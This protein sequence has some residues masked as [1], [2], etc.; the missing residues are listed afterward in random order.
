LGNLNGNP[1]SG[2]ELCLIPSLGGSISFGGSHNYDG[3]FAIGLA[4]GGYPVV[5]PPTFSANPV[6]AGSSVTVSAAVTGTGPFTYQWQTDGGNGGALTDIP[7]ATNPT[8]TVNTTGLDNLTVA[9]RLV[10]SNGAGSTTGEASLLTVNPGSGPFVRPGFDTTPS[11]ADRFVGGAVTFTAR[12]DGTLPISYQ[13][14][15]NK[16]S[17]PE[18]LAGQ[19][20]DTLVLSNL[21]LADAGQYSLHAI[22]SV[23]AADSTPSTLTVLPQPA[24]PMTVNLQWRSFQ[25]GNDVGVYS[26]TGVLGSGTYWN[27]IIGPTAGSTPGTFTSDAPGYAD[28]GVTVAGLSMTI[29]SSES[30]CW[31]S[32]PTIPLLDSAATAFGTQNFSFIL[33]NGLYNIVLFSCDGTEAGTDTQ[34]GTIFDIKGVTH[35]AAPTQ[36]TSFVAGDNYVVFS[37]VVVTTGALTGT[38]SQNTA[39]GARVG[40]LN[41][42]Q[43]EYLGAVNTTQPD[44]IA[45]AA[46]GQ[47]SLSWPGHGGWTLQV[48]TNS[49][50][51][52]WVDVVGSSENTQIN[53][54]ISP[55][56]GAAFYRMVLKP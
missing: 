16:G 52:N 56:I 33:P 18:D 5:T 7:G 1:Y 20:N 24:S 38:W 29:V 26:G 55:A 11:P 50:G 9:Y 53:I 37:N 3:V 12:F 45:K 17:G 25:G 41:G 51:T 13:W 19:T 40:N 35:I 36:D 14:Q 8:M 15:V 30:W 4:L 39:A 54:P 21:Q 34:S 47:L 44:I 2:G 31:T 27:Q 6:Y 49:L 23:G 32:T 42:A 10:A 46:G 28:D 48:Q 22:N 43:V